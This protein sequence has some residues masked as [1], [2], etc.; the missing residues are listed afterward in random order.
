MVHRGHGIAQDEPPCPNKKCRIGGISFALWELAQYQIEREDPR[1]I[2]AAADG[3]GEFRSTL[4][5]AFTRANEALRPVMC[6]D[7]L[8][9][10]ANA[11]RAVTAECPSI[12]RHRLN[13]LIEA[14]DVYRD[15]LRLLLVSRQLQQ[16]TDCRPSQRLLT[17]VY[18]HLKWGGFSY[19]GLADLD[20]G[21][22]EFVIPTLA[23][24]MRVDAG[25]AEPVER[26]ERLRRKGEAAAKRLKAADAIRKRLRSSP[27]M[28]WI[29]P[30]S[31]PKGRPEP[32]KAAD[33]ST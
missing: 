7:D 19:G 3:L 27:D 29:H 5:S 14:V 24:L 25:L 20:L 2:N 16:R 17:A 26:L 6:R 15:Q 23:E 10:D 21:N 33:T 13:A 28:R 32:S 4:V 30:Y 22:K 12:M 9:F 31:P 8:S 1:G 18:Q 11:V